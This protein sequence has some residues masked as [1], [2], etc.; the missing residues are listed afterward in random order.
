[1]IQYLWHKSAVFKIKLSTIL[2]NTVYT[3]WTRSRKNSVV[4]LVYSIDPLKV[5]MKLH[6]GL[7]CPTCKLYM[8]G[9]TFSD[10]VPLHYIRKWTLVTSKH[11]IISIKWH[12][13]DNINSTSDNNSK[14]FQDNMPWRKT[15]YMF[16][17]QHALEKN[18]LHVPSVP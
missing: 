6:P 9:R 18:H 5:L 17:G 11:K 3:N 7:C 1:M 16:P 15:I 8:P 14:K 2:I 12:L 13:K 4:Q 10:R